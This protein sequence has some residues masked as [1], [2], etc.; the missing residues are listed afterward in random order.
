MRGSVLRRPAASFWRWRRGDGGVRARVLGD[1]IGVGAQAVAGTLDLHD[2]GVVEQPRARERRA[3][4][5][6]RGAPGLPRQ[7]PLRPARRAAA[8]LGRLRRGHA[9]ALI[10]LLH[11]LN[12]HLTCRSRRSPMTKD[13]ISE[14]AALKALLSETADHQILAEMLGFC[15][16]PFDGAGCGPAVR[17][18]VA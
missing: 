15:R 17:C 2:D 7:E 11:F 16:R 9:T 10:P 18:R 1:Q 4:D 12:S 5:P 6:H 3:G 8:R 14:T 13:T